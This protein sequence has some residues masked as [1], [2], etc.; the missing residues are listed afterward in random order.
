M[1]RP[2][3]NES[4]ADFAA[5]TVRREHAPAK[6]RWIAVLAACAWAA[7]VWFGREGRADL[8]DRLTLAAAGL[9]A[10]ALLVCRGWERLA[11]F[12]ALL[13]AGLLWLKAHGG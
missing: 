7:A 3:R 4:P 8:R 12:L 9:G 5:R 6:T 11:G 1:S 10:A 13:G 2:R